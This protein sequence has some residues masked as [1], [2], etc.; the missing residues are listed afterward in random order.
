MTSHPGAQGTHA[1]LVQA[2][3]GRVASGDLPSGTVLTLADL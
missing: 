1:R 3:G 2:L